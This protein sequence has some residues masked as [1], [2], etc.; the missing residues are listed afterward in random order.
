MF[1]CFSMSLLD[2]LFNFAWHLIFFPVRTVKR[3][4][5]KTFVAKCRFLFSR[6][7]DDT[8]VWIIYRYVY[9]HFTLALYTTK[10][11]IHVLSFECWT[12]FRWDYLTIFHFQDGVSWAHV[13]STPFGSFWWKIIIEVFKFE[14]CVNWYVFLRK[15][16][17]YVCRVS[18]GCLSLN[19]I[20]LGLCLL[21]V[22]NLMM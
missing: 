20:I 22:R 21:T 6:N 10:I 14:P 7:P 5:T 17:S 4:V 9:D 2:L 18:K 11:S 15:L 1:F 3:L 16:R 13:E 8:S 19:L 12:F